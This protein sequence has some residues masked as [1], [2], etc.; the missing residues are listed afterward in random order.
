MDKPTIAITMGDAAGIG[1]E[2]IVKILSE[3]TIYKQ[4]N[5]LL[6]GDPE[7]MREICQIVGVE[8]RFQRIDEPTDARFSP[9]VVDVLH[10]DGLQIDHVAWGQLDPGM[11][12]AAAQCLKTS[13]ELA[14]KGQIHGVVSAPLNKEAFHQAGYDYLDEVAYLA[15]LTGSSETF[16]MGVMGAIWTV[17][18][19]EH[20]AFRDILALIKKNRILSYIVRLHDALTE[21]GRERPRIAVA[22]LNVHAGEGG[23]FGREEIDE[24]APA[25][26]AAQNKDI[27]AHGPVPAD[28]VF[29]LALEGHFD[30]VVCMYHDQANIAR[31]LQPKGEGAT[32]F[33]GL[34]V[35]CGTTAHGTAFDIA[36]QGIADPG[37]LRAALRYII[38]LS[39]QAHV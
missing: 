27:S 35:A 10:P 39:S 8:L 32:I 1:P 20:I 31:K 19:T 2:L 9:P 15:D 24:I 23:L 3:P 34:P 36:G 12:H 16:I 14:G 13:F 26:E 6:I 22:A 7:V 30:G 17:A 33:M 21:V 4:C 11:G 29:V 37:S 38:Q 25:I 5:P 18:V 28:M